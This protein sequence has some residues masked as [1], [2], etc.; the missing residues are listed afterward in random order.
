M[1]EGDEVE[2]LLEASGVCASLKEIQEGFARK[3]IDR[4]R[5]DG[6]TL[7][8]MFEQIKKEIENDSAN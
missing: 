5:R 2:A 3:W 8:E 4:Q 6:K 1:Y 7:A